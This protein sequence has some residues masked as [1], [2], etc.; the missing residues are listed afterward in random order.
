MA[1]GIM[2]RA[3]RRCCICWHLEGDLAVKDLQIAHLDRNRANNAPRNLVGLCLPHHDA[4]DTRRKQT[5]NFTAGEVRI[6]R[7]ELDA[8][9]AKRNETL[10]MRVTSAVGVTS[11]QL[12][13]ASILGR[14]VDAYDRAAAGIPMPRSGRGRLPRRPGRRRYINRRPAR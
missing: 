8:I 6:Y 7:D 14:V 3:G 1:D 4:Y 12:S 9:L 2:A 11:A 13:S 5:R 10:V